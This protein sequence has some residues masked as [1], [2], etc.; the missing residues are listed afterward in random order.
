MKLLCFLYHSINSCFSYNCFLTCRLVKYSRGFSRYNIAVNLQLNSG[1]VRGH[2]SNISIL[3]LK[4]IILYVGESKSVHMPQECGGQRTA[5]GSWLSL[6]TIWIV[7]IQLQSSGSM[8]NFYLSSYLSGV[9]CHWELWRAPCCVPYVIRK[10][11]VLFL[12]NLVLLTRIKLFN[13]R[14]YK[15]YWEGSSR[16]ILLEFERDV[17][18]QSGYKWEMKVRRR[19][20][21]HV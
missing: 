11:G 13:K 18:G 14:I 8:T 15:I 19:G 4:N 12:E 16:V 3:Y 1:V 6:C 9:L 20:S 10:I 21:I 7:G 17:K 2:I 5:F